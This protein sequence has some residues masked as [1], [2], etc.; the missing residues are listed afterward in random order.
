MLSGFIDWRGS[1]EWRRQVSREEGRE[2]PASRWWDFF[3]GRITWMDRW[4]CHLSFSTLQ[5]L[6]LHLCIGAIY[7]SFGLCSHQCKSNARIHSCCM[8]EKKQRG[9]HFTVLTALPTL[10][11]SLCECSWS[12]TEWSSASGGLLSSKPSSSHR[13]APCSITTLTQRT[14]SS[15]CGPRWSPGL[16]WIQIYL[17][18]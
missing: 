7:S 13:R 8:E 3:T 4:V 1:G 2:L 16:R 9:S 14:K 6:Q 15:N 11:V 18:R 10:C 12:T 5:L 17:F